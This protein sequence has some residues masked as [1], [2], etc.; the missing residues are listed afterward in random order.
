MS[1]RHTYGM[2]AVPTDTNYDP[3]TGTVWAIDLGS[4][5]NVR[6]P[7][8]Q[9]TPVTC[10]LINGTQ[11]FPYSLA[12]CGGTNVLSVNYVTGVA[13]GSAPAAAPS[14][15]VPSQTAAVSNGA[16]PGLPS[17]A[18][19]SGTS[20]GVAAPADFV[21]SAISWIQANPWLAGGIAV[22]VL[23]LAVKR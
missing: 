17:S 3:A 21:S 1:Y 10:S 22:G 7:L 12:Q 13:P 19:T 23:F 6:V 18:A 4:G 5:Q 20:V 8:A 2:G 15:P 9:A 14:S 11:N 16:V